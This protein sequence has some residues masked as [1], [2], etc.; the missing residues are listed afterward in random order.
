MFNPN[1]NQEITADE[2]LKVYKASPGY[3]NDEAQVRQDFETINPSG[4]SI[5]PE[6]F[7]KILNAQEGGQQQQSQNVRGSRY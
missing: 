3:Q 4:K 1:N 5:S 6:E 7:L 2:F